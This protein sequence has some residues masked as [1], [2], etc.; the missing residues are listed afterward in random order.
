MISMLL[1]KVLI[2]LNFININHS[3]ATMPPKDTIK[4]KRE[5]ASYE[6][7]LQP[8]LT[9][10]LYVTSPYGWRYHPVLGKRLKHNGVDLRAKFQPVYSISIGTIEKIGKD[11]RSGNYVIIDNFNNIET[12][13][14]HL[15]K[16]VVHVGDTVRA[17]QAFAISGATGKVTGPHLHFGIKVKGKYINPLP[18]LKAIIRRNYK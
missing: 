6:F 3:A 18:I 14:C 11:T 15:S 12:I 8:P 1:I 10:K 13:F 16:V 17:G 4:V 7:R 9:N 2:F 5:R